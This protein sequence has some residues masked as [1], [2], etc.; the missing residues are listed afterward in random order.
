MLSALD[1]GAPHK[2][3]RWW[4]LARPMRNLERFQSQQQRWSKAPFL[5]GEHVQAWRLADADGEGLE[6]FGRGSQQPRSTDG[7]WWATEPDMGRVAH[8]VPARVDR[9]KGLGNAVVPGCAREAFRQL[10]GFR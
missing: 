10:M 6:R 1:M 9:L 7:S 3:E 8:G 5:F 2:R 4:L